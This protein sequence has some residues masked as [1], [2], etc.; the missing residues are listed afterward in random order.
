[1][2]AEPNDGNQ[3]FIPGGG[4]ISTSYELCERLP[5]VA[6]SRARVCRVCQ[7]FSYRMYIDSNRHN[8]LEYE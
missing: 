2:A 3:D 7:V 6:C 8:T 1:M 5:Y 4:A